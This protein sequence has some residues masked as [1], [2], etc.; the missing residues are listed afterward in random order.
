MVKPSGPVTGT[1]ALSTIN[2]DHPLPRKNRSSNSDG[3]TRLPVAQD[4]AELAGVSIAT[5]SR[6][7]NEPEKVRPATREAV[8]KAAA[9]LGFVLNSAARALSTRRS[10]TVGVIVPS[11][12]NEVFVRA[13]SSFQRTMRAAGYQ[14]LAASSEYDLATEMQE[15]TFLLQR[16]V[17]GLML[18]GGI[19]DPALYARAERSQVP[20][21][22]SFS[23]S[24]REYCVGF[25]NREAT[26][27]AANY[28]L[29]L[30]HK[31]LAVVTGTRENNDRAAPRAEGCAS[32][33]AERGLELSPAHD[34]IVSSGIVAGRDAFSQLMGGPEEQRPTAII[35]GTDEI[36]LGIM[37][38]ASERGI[39]IP[40]ALSVIG[41]ND[42]SFSAVL[43]PPLTTIRVDADEIGKSSALA[44]L[45]LMGAKTMVQVTRITP[46]LVLRGTVAPPD[47]L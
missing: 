24:D 8:M 45:N 11:Y 46:E 19:H 26:F 15:V 27:R 6:A 16:G 18:V 5:V 20:I 25:D 39:D 37:S 42:S 12:G 28:L 22:Q 21:I 44:L 10:S 2:P 33:M 47:K 1:Q 30:G 43:S 29:D 3:R 36:A 13:L 23:L 31:R 7:L 40:R 38:E 34:L 14:V 35:C 9:E 17:D 4:V 32:A 41:F